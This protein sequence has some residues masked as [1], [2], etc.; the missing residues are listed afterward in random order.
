[1]F[2]EKGNEQEDQDT[3]ILIVASW[4]SGR[5]LA[6]ESGGHGSSPGCS[7]STLSHWERLYTCIYSPHLCVKQVPD[8]RQR[9]RVTCHL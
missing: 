1:M 6:S 8:Y 3:I 5:H 9:T 7:R 4:F 2:T